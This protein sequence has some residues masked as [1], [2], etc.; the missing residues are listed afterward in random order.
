MVFVFLISVVLLDIKIVCEFGLCL[1]WESRLVVINLGF[2]NLLVSINIFDGL[3]GILIVV[4]LVCWFI[5]CLVLVIKLL[6]GLKILF[7]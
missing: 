3:V 5:C 6:F 2:V 1:V 4:L 7:I